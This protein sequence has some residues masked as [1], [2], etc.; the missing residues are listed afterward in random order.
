ACDPNGLRKLRGANSDA[1]FPRNLGKIQSESHP[2]RRNGC[3][4]VYLAQQFQLSQTVEVQ[5]PYPPL[6]HLLD[7]AAIEVAPA[8]CDFFRREA[9]FETE[10]HIPGRVRV[11]TPT[12]F[13]KDAQKRQVSVRHA[14]KTKS[15]VGIID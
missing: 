10:I 7:L 11:Q 5:R 15:S 6:Q 4:V 12:A 8:I 13:A 2:R 1:A 9:G 3:P 14:C